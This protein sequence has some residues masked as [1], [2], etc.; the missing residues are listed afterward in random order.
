MSHCNNGIFLVT[1][2]HGTCLHFIETVGYSACLR[3]DPLSWVMLLLWVF[4]KN[5]SYTITLCH[6]IYLIK[7]RLP[8]I[9]SCHSMFKGYL[10]V[11]ITLSSQ[12]YI[13]FVLVTFEP[14]PWILHTQIP[15]LCSDFCVIDVGF[16]MALL[17]REYS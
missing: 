14:V 8:N 7:S 15:E 6:G 2:E 4:S 3:V 12:T 11:K 1:F 16:I 10:C 17:R 9:L 13:Y 5:A